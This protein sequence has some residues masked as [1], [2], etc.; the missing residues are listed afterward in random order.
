MIH[1]ATVEVTCDGES[2]T[3]SVYAELNWVY[4]GINHTDGRYDADDKAIEA[5]IVRDHE[6]FVDGTNQYCSE[7][8]RDEK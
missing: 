6:W 5:T 2:C 1:D 8:C 7:R 4:G 3:A